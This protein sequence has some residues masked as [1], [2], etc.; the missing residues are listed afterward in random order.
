[1]ERSNISYGGKK[2]RLSELEYHW[3][4]RKWLLMNGEAIPNMHLFGTYK[5]SWVFTKPPLY[6]FNIIYAHLH[7]CYLISLLCMDVYLFYSGNIYLKSLTFCRGDSHLLFSREILEWRL[8]NLNAVGNEV[9][10]D[11]GNIPR[12]FALKNG[13]KQPFHNIIFS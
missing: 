7:I 4:N 9:S 2:S 1:M 3:K 5:V 11:A 6:V 10:H 13:S 8:Y 12:K